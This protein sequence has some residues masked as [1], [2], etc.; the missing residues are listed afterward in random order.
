MVYI[1]LFKFL[2]SHTTPDSTNHLLCMYCPITLFNAILCLTSVS[3]MCL[4]PCDTTPVQLPIRCLWHYDG[5]NA[6]Y[7]SEDTYLHVLLSGGNNI[8]DTNMD[9]NCAACVHLQF[10][11]PAN[12]VTF[13]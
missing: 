2:F 11:T 1:L 8:I 10:P 9:S 7:I 5:I 12:S 13:G 6:S 3:N 4:I